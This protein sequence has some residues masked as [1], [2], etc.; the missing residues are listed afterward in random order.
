[1]IIP[2]V[3]RIP[4]GKFREVGR[5]EPGSRERASDLKPIMKISDCCYLK[6]WNPNTHTMLASTFKNPDREILTLLMYFHNGRVNSNGPKGRT[7]YANTDESPNCVF[8][9]N[10]SREFFM[11]R[12]LTHRTRV[13]NILFPVIARMRHRC[14]A[15]IPHG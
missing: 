14:E 11:P 7:P 9:G 10:S 3:D 4:S 6:R 15:A 8:L 1:M 13:S 5:R 2:Y 12:G